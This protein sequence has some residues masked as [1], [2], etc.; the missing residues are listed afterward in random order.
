VDYDEDEFDIKDYSDDSNNDNDDDDE[1]DMNDKMDPDSITALSDP[2][3]L[4]DDED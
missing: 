4:Q 3:T 1:E 2:T